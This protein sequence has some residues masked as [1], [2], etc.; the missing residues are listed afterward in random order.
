MARRSGPGTPAPSP[1][2]CASGNANWPPGAACRDTTAASGG[3]RPARQRENHPDPGRMARWHDAPA[4]ERRHQA[5]PAAR[6]ETLTGP[7]AQHA[8]IP[9]PPA[10][11]RGLPA[12]EKTTLIQAEWHDGTTLRPRNAGTKPP[13]L[14][15]WKR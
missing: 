11:V 8:A 2:R 3:A 4:P 6:L 15:V 10:A 5:P 14:R 13:P 1:P 12:S 7:Q 9:P